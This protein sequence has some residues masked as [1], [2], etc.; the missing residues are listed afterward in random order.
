MAK[1]T[2]KAASNSAKPTKQYIINSNVKFWGEVLI[3]WSY[4]DKEVA[5]KIAKIFWKDIYTIKPL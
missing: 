5:E 4:V 2:K 1:K 3:R